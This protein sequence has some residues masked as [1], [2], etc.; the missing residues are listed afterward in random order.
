MVPRQTQV[1]SLLRSYALGS[2]GAALVTDSFLSSAA[3][4]A[5]H[6]ALI[7]DLA[8]AYNVEFSKESARGISLALGVAFVPGWLGGEVQ[9]SILR[10]LPVVTGVVGVIVVAGMSAAVTYALGRTVIEH[11][12]AGGTLVD[13]DVKRLHQAVE[14]LFNSGNPVT[15]VA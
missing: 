13:F 1:A 15:P 3:I 11:F 12:E 9:R 5:L 4:A 7:R 10:V 8:A 6:L 14:N 2:S